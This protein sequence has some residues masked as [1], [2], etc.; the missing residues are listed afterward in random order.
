MNTL[1][2]SRSPLMKEELL[3][4]L[5][6]QYVA[7]AQTSLDLT[8]YTVRCHLILERYLEI[9]LDYGFPTFYWRNCRLLGSF[10]AKCEF[11][12]CSDHIT[13]KE[14]LPGIKALHALRNELV[15]SLEAVN[16]LPSLC[17]NLA[18]NLPA[19]LRPIYT[20]LEL[21]IPNAFADERFQKMLIQGM[22][23][24]P[25]AYTLGFA[26]GYLSRQKR[27]PRELL[28]KIEEIAL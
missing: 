19:A 12:S 7:M 18:N 21:D 17:R 15:H 27:S 26:E 8:S 2:P 23:K 6:D 9:F 10:G 16:K 1:S 25:C 20:S 3:S 13:V 28:K 4:I 22:A 11:L 5:R 14:M 24:Y